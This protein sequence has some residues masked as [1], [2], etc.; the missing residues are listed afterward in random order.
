MQHACVFRADLLKVDQKSRLRKRRAPA[1][2]GER[3][4]RARRRHLRSIRG[5]NDQTNRRTDETDA[6]NEFARRSHRPTARVDQVIRQC[7][8]DDA[9]R[10]HGGPRKR[11]KPRGFSEVKTDDLLE[12]ERHPRQKDEKT[13]V[14]DKVGDD[15][16][17][18]RG[19][20][21]Q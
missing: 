6:L 9:A 18:G 21:Q 2:D 5:Q 8:R 1:R 16:R 12:I 3:R 13:P 19:F 11:A 20:G 15:A 10:R 14:I 4:H 7:S 17:P